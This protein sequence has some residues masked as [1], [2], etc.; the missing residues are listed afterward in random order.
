[1]SPDFDIIMRMDPLPWQLQIA[2]KSLKKKEK[3]DLIRNDIEVAPSDILLD[4]GCA[5]GILSW[6]LRK[7]GGFWVSTDLDFTNL[8]TSQALLGSNLVQ[9]SVDGLP[10]LDAAFDRVVCLDY[11]EHVDDDDLTLREIR[12]VLQPGGRLILVTPHTGKLFLL[13]KL[14]PLVGLKL[15]YYGHK[16]EGYGCR[17][18][19]AKLGAA[20]MRFI[21]HKT[22]SRFFTELLELILN[23]GYVN[24]LSKKPEAKL[25]DGH[26]RPSTA[27]EF[28]SQRKAFKLYKVVYPFVWL[29]SRLDKLL[30]FLRGNAIIVWA[31][32]PE[33]T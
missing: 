27:D 9:M 31:E 32:K 30:F 7:R 6:F 29:V 18:L 3:I 14:R 11:L 25:R 20:G 22:Y 8:K 12:R 13:Q 10:F 24:L 28:A 33:E 1:M 23:A 5:Q 19:E 2:G 4:L 15:E 21:R 26:I 16:R 17:T